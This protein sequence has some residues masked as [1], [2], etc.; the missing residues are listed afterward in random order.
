MSEV[1]HI[2]CRLLERNILPRCVRVAD[3]THT[4]AYALLLPASY[5]T[6][7]EVLTVA[8]EIADDLRAIVNCMATLTAP[9]T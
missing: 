3:K 4:R 5:N 9:A 7:R 1:V 6:A 8:T 2:W